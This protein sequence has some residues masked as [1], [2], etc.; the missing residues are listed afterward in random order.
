VLLLVDE[1]RAVLEGL[2]GDLG[3]RFGV[4]YQLRAECSPTA[5]LT[6]FRQLAAESQQV[7]LVLAGQSMTQMSG[8]QFLVA[9]HEVHPAAKRVLLVGRGDY[10]AAHPAVRA[11]TLGQI[12]C[13]AWRPWRAPGCSTAPRA[14]K[15]RRWK[16]KWCL[17]SAP[18]T[19]RGRPPFTWPNTR[20]R[21]LC[22]SAATPSARRC[23]TTWSP[24]SGRPPTSPFGYAR[25]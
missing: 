3:R 15:P 18:A 6:T 19:R 7:A 4:D 1:D 17:W 22:W 12:D 5:A 21:S 9:A 2:S 16:A 11:M 20:R 13:R 14:V 8:V 23:P 25:R 10:S 24:S